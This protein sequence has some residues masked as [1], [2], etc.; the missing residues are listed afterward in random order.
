MRI[1]TTMFRVSFVI[2]ALLMLGCNANQRSSSTA[3][4]PDADPQVLAAAKEQC[5][6]DK[7]PADAIAM[8]ELWTR[9]TG[10][11]VTHDHDHADDAHADD[12]HA[13]HDHDVHADHDHDVHDDHDH[14]AH[15]HDA[16]DDHDHDAHDD[17]ERVA[18]VAR[19]APMEQTAE[20]PGRSV[21]SWPGHVLRRRS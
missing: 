2:A 19:I 6:L 9:I 11:V 7:E 10:E 17:A 8:S 21:E 1:A 12:T 14:D 18:F 16:H 20:A 4:I 3:N 13:D 5:L 15:D